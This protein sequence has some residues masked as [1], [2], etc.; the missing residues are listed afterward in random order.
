MVLQIIWYCIG[1]IGAF[2]I[3]SLVIRRGIPLLNPLAGKS[4]TTT[5][6]ESSSGNPVFDVRSTGFWI[7]LCETILVF[8]FVGAHE[9][10]ALAIIIGAKEFVRK[11]DIK[12]NPSYY[13]LGTLANLS[14]AIV[15]AQFIFH[16]T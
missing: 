8:I 9:Y 6:P 11:D 15:I 10:G 16:V 14:I 7:G 4:Q 2:T 1:V 12:E 3:S 13:L 5:L